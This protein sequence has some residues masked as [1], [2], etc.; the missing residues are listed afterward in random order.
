[1]SEQSLVEAVHSGHAPAWAGQDQALG[2]PGRVRPAPSLIDMAWELV[3]RDAELERARTL[4]ESKTGVALLGPAGVGKSR[5]LREVLDRVDATTLPTSRFAATE[6]TRSIPFAPFATL[7]PDAPA[8]DRLEVFR[9][10]LAGLRSQVG[11]RGLLLGVDDAHHLD[12]GSLALLTA[13]TREDDITVCLTAR[14]GEPM[15]AD[16]VDLWTDGVMARIDIGPLGHAEVLAL[17]DATLGPCDPALVEELWRLSAGNPL[18]LHELVE[19]AAGQTM[20]RGADGIWRQTAELTDSPRLVDLIT[21]RL[22]RVP[23]EVRGAMALVAVGD[24]VPLTLLEE[25]AGPQV[26]ELERLNLI[27]IARDDDDPS[28]T[29]AHPLYGEMLKRRLSVTQTREA[30]RS[31]L[32]AA[33]RLKT[34]PDA[35]RTALWQ[36]DAGGI[37]HPEIA[38]AGARAALARHDGRLAERLVRPVAGSSPHADITL[39]RALTLRHRFSDAEEVFQTIRAD[40][41]NALGELASARAHNL[42]FGLG[43]VT[44]AVEVLAEAARIVDAAARARLDTERGVISAMRGDFVDAEAS[45]RAV[46]ANAAATAPARAAGYVN[47]ALSLAMTADCREFDGMLPDAYAAAHAAR[48]EV[49]FAE[50]QIGVMEFCARCAAGRIAEAVALGR[51]GVARSSGSALHSTWLSASAMGLDL[52]GWLVEALQAATQAR[53][54]MGAS[55]PFGL[56]RQARGLQA[57]AR[58]QRGDPAAVE[59]V[60]DIPLNEAEPRVT[61]WVRRGLVWAAAADGRTDEAAEQAVTAGREGTAGQ[62]YAWA[63]QALHDAVRLGRPGLVADELAALRNDHGAE[64]INTMADHADA[65]A[66]DDADGL[67]AVSAAF[68]RMCA[69]LL[70]AEAAAQASMRLDGAEAALACCLSLGWERRCQA[71]RTPALTGRPP[72][73]SMREVEVAIKAA[74][75]HTSPQIADELF[76]SSRTV[77]NHLRSVYRKLGLS[78]RAELSRALAPL[79]TDALTANES[80]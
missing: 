15:D 28:A 77:D 23:E 47:L 4:V 44:D 59:D 26:E 64:L 79:T 32:H 33:V 36:H 66:G 73:V 60:H 56:E 65:L 43:R 34:V 69:P 1:M 2:S 63:A 9:E 37:E 46:I 8:W 19:G 45:G 17:L 76:L 39:G 10:A 41:A 78:G 48:T 5:L 61:I 7:V 20:D 75:G 52:A 3:G 14:A 38:V 40:T 58:G 50:G 55:D 29:P 30:N 31:L 25:A 49:P 71:P 62:H 11:P 13:V 53:S 21:A 42:A 16:L 72:H 6:A 27:D 24:P 67:L 54:L 57:M 18:V 74:R 70:A 68:G 51:R 35:L 12:A 22:L 80:D